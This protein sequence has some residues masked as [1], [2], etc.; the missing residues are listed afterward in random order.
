MTEQRHYI[1]EMGGR[2][3]EI[4]VCD[5]FKQLFHTCSLNGMHNSCHTCS[6]DAK[7]FSQQ[8]SIYITM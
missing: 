1:E 3:F 5:F 4:T 6:S 7:S 8:V 2:R